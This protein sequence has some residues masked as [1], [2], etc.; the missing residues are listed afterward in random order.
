MRSAGEDLIRVQA[1]LYE[2]EE[3][4][5][6]TSTQEELAE[7]AT[8]VATGS[9]LLKLETSSLTVPGEEVI[10]RHLT[11]L[12]FPSEY[13]DAKLLRSATDTETYS[14]KDTGDS[15]DG[16]TLI[17][18]VQPTRLTSAE[19]GTTLSIVPTL[20]SNGSIHLKGSLDEVT[21]VDLTEENSPS[22][23]TASRGTNGNRQVELTTNSKKSPVLHTSRT[24]ISATLPDQK[25]THYVI[26]KAKTSC[27]KDPANLP[28]SETTIATGTTVRTLTIP[29]KDSQIPIH[30]A[31][32]EAEEFLLLALRAEAIEIKSPPKPTKDRKIYVTVR[33]VES[34][35][36]DSRVAPILTD[37]QFQLE[38]RRLNQ[39]KGVDLLSAPSVM[40][41]SG[42]RASIEVG[43]RLT[44]PTAYDPPAFGPGLS[45]QEGT[46]PVSPSAPTVFEHQQLGIKMELTATLR[47]DGLIEVRT[48]TRIKEP[49]GFLNYGNPVVMVERRALGKPV[50]VVIT[51]NQIQAP[52]TSAR[53]QTSTIV[54]QDGHTGVAMS[55][56]DT[57]SIKIEDKGLLGL[58]KNEYVE[59]TPR[60][61]TAFVRA[62]LMD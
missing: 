5:S 34:D 47:S 45:T 56:T 41:V 13:T 16:S 1:T 3:A 29:N 49:S 30:P 39:E 32:P 46:F 15:K 54:L 51:E 18:P 11:K 44:F 6:S 26:V 7:L 42:Q 40:A 36:A 59:R 38:I 8:K 19:T 4:V 27:L 20:K 50:P 12:Y 53:E 43:E 37:P 62:Q 58:T 31:R 22:R 24:A 57:R 21:L 17:V 10:S 9:R 28:A 14:L 48:D 23:V 52:V 25:S 2:L 61:L 35:D 60:H 33:F 55:L